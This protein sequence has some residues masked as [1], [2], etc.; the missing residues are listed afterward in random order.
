MSIE[1][2][3]NILNEKSSRPTYCYPLRVKQIKNN[4]WIAWFRG[5]K[6]AKGNGIDPL[7][8]VI[9]LVCNNMGVIKKAN[10]GN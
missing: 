1:K 9:T 3:L 7:N 5:I 4:E 8:A 10:K 6:K 2:I